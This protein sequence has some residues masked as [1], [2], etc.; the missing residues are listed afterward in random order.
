[1]LSNFESGKNKEC[2]PTMHTHST[3]LHAVL[4]SNRSDA[5]EIAEKIFGAIPLPNT[6][7]YSTLI[8][9]YARKGDVEI[10]LRLLHQMQLDFQSGKNT[11]CRPSLQTY[12][13][14]LKALQKSNRSDTVE[15]A[16]KIFSAIL[17]PDTVTYTTLI[18]IYAQQGSVEKAMKLLH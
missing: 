5:V 4:K 16:E 15:M 10:S 18:N 14:I 9:I 3:I 8:N 11:E 12:N 13:I 2:R 17:L 1:M 6:V 7:T